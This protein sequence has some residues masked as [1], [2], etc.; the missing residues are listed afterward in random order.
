MRGPG[1][2]DEF[3]RPDERRDG[4]GQARLRSLIRVSGADDA[5]ALAALFGDEL[6]GKMRRRDA[7]RTARVAADT[8][9]RRAELETAVEDA[10]RAFILRMD[11]PPG[12]IIDGRARF[13][14][15]SGS[16]EGSFRT[17]D[18]VSEHTIGSPERYGWDRKL[19]A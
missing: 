15:S 7:A 6:P 18:L 1:L 9:A 11:G 13:V 4:V 19:T 16:G 14:D 8:V 12:T 10:V 3:E 2:F 17:P 5:D